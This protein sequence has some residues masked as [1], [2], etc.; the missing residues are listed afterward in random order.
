MAR[1]VV[2]ILGMCF[3]GILGISSTSHSSDT[4]TY[5][6]GWGGTGSGDGEFR[7][8]SGI[9]IDSSGSIFV[10][11]HLNHRVQQFLPD[12]TF[13][14]Q[15]P[16]GG[17]TTGDRPWD[18]DL[19]SN[20]AII[21][22]TENSIRRFSSNGVLLQDWGPGGNGIAIGQDGSY[23]TANGDQ[24]KVLKTTSDGTLLLEWGEEGYGNGQFKF[25]QGVAVDDLGNVY[26][27]CIASHRIQKF[28]SSGQFL[29]ELPAP[30]PYGLYGFSD[31][32][33]HGTDIY[34]VAMDVNIICR[35]SLSGTLISTWGT[36]GS[37]P[38]DFGCPYRCAVDAD[39]NIYITEGCNDRVQKFSYE[40]VA[41]SSTTWGR[42]KSSY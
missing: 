8:A 4:P 30:D 41:T 19:D 32:V 11:D 16:V 28:T 10:A 12:G 25:P 40:S 39:G 24:K 7:T 5:V 9:V 42:I 23:Y 13:K 20:G 1:Y 38:G 36:P 17:T 22:A 21:V 27:T 26:V 35:Y 6:L 14:A 29:T 34:I 33:I 2:T 37:E 18:L 31:V 15:W 3:L